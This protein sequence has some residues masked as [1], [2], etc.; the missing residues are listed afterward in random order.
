M[1]TTTDSGPLLEPLDTFYLVEIL[2]K[3]IKTL[4]SGNQGRKNAKPAPERYTPE[5]CMV[6]KV[7]IWYI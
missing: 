1:M 7:I 3:P 2:L 6:A 5:F 4:N